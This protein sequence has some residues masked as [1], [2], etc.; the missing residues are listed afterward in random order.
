MPGVARISIEGATALEVFVI[1]PE[2][3]FKIRAMPIW[4][5]TVLER[6]AQGLAASQTD[7]ALIKKDGEQCVLYWQLCWVVRSRVLQQLADRRRY[8]SVI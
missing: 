3:C 8:L 5:L 1:E 2:P 7:T 4:I 6:N